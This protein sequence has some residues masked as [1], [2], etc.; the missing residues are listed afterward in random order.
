[1]HERHKPCHTYSIE[2]GDGDHVL[3]QQLRIADFLQ[4]EEPLE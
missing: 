3:P 4:A 2:S 1:M